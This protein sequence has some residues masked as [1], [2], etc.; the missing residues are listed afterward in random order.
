MVHIAIYIQFLFVSM[1][2]NLKMVQGPDY[3]K[4]L[5]LMQDVAS[6]KIYVRLG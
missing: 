3:P 5:L 2:S 6:S 4:I 1:Y